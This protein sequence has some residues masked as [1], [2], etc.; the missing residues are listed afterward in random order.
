MHGAIAIY[1]GQLADTE[2]ESTGY[3]S[4]YAPMWK[5]VFVG[6]V[7]YS[8]QKRIHLSA[9]HIDAIK[10]IIGK[11]TIGEL[12]DTAA[13]L[14]NLEA[15]LDLYVDQAERFL[16]DELGERPGPFIAMSPHVPDAA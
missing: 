16:V 14:N 4:E 2:I 7:V 6:L 13:L 12:N 1:A 8:A 15:L 3:P 9:R 5:E 11:A 10:N